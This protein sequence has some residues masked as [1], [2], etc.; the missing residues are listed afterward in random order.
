MT[1]EEI[2]NQIASHMIEGISYH[3][4]MARAYNFIGL[5]GFAKCQVSHCCEE[6][7]NLFCLRQYYATHYFKLLQEEHTHHPEIIPSTWYKY[8]T[9]AVDTSTKKQA[10]KEL[11]NKWVEWERSTKTFYQA[12]RQELMSISEHAAANYLDNFIIAVTKELMT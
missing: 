11:M 9:H 2:F 8:T 5:W 3:E 12:M 7:N 6:H 10:V 4:E 1:V